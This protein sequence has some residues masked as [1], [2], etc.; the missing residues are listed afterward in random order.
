MLHRMK[1]A[2]RLSSERCSAVVIKNM[3][4]DDQ[5]QCAFDH[6]LIHSCIHTN[7]TIM[8]LIGNLAAADRITRL[9]ISAVIVTLFAADL[10]GGPLAA[11]LLSLSVV[12]TLTAVVGFCPL[13]KVFG[14]DNK[15][16][17]V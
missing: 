4:G 1:G 2:A 8:K 3:M 14:F 11:G 5:D 9:V 13:Y 10:I 7:S 6:A 15:K 16:K 17:S 12:L